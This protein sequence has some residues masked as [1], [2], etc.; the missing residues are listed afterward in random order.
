MLSE[1]QERVAGIVA[2]LAEA[3][4]FVLAGGAALILHGMV[5]RST[6]DL[7]YFATASGAVAALLLCHDVHLRV[8][9]RTLPW[10][11]VSHS[12]RP[13]NPD[14]EHRGFDR[15]RFIEMLG[16][17]DRLRDAD[18]PD[19]QSAG[20]LRG[21]YAQWRRELTDSLQDRERGRGR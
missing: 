3:D 17:I 16:A 6:R 1:L 20:E 19:P 8:V 2:E 5:E 10:R 13:V 4:D 7:D 9:S 11:G 12:N 15:R 14:A 18:F 21:W